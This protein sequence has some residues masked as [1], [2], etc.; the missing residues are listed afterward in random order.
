MS[1]HIFLVLGFQFQCFYLDI[2][3]RHHLVC[4]SKCDLLFCLKHG[5]RFHVHLE[6]FAERIQWRR[7]ERDAVVQQWVQRYADRLAARCLEAPLQWFNF[8]PFWNTH[9]QR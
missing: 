2:L 7:G 5:E 4:L 3:S 1:R 8:Y 9:D 6:P